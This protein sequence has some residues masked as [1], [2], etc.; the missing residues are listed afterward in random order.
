MRHYLP[1]ISMVRGTFN[2]TTANVTSNSPVTITYYPTL[3][4][5]QNENAA[6]LITNTTAYTAT[7]GT[8]VYA[9]VNDHIG[10]KNIAQIT[11]SL[12]NKAIVQDNYNGV[13][14]DDNLDGTVNVVL[15]N[16]TP[17][18]LNNPNYFTNVRYYANLADA[19]AG[20]TIRSL[21]AGVIQQLQP[22]TSG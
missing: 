19:N 4:D 5:A 17:I 21:I 18:V 6:A 20:I 11:L 8:I 1:V 10:C 12:F 2:L 13:F 9:L 15:S 22:F 7:N 16:I 3:A 14:C